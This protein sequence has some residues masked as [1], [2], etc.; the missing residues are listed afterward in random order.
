MFYICFPISYKLNLLPIEKTINQ[1][2]Q[3]LDEAH[4]I[5]TSNLKGSLALAKEAL[6]LSKK[7]NNLPYIAKCM[8]RLSL[9]NMI[10]GKTNT[11]TSY[12]NKAISYFEELN[13]ETGIADSKYSLAAVHYKTN[14]YHMGLVCL[15]DALKIYHKKNDYSNIS[16]TEKALGTVYEYIGDEKNA[17]IS[18]KNAIRAARIVNDLNL[19]S[20]VYNNL[21]G[22][23]VKKSKYKYSM[24][25]IERSIELK[26]QTKDIRGSGF[27]IYGRG[28]VFLRLNKL[29]EAE[30]DFKAAFDIHKKMGDI[31]GLS[32]S[33]TKLGELYFKDNKHDLAIQYALDG[34]KLT[35]KHNITM[36]NIKLFNLVYNIYKKIGKIELALEYLEYY[37]KEKESLIDIQTIKVIENYDFILKMKTLEKDNQIQKEKQEMLEIKRQDELRALKLKQEFLS[38]MSHEIRTPLNAITSIVALLNDEINEEGKDLLKSLKF[39]SSNLIKIVNDVLDFTKLDSNKSNLEVTTVNLFQLTENIKN[40]YIKQAEDKGLLLK[41]N[42]EIEDTC[43]YK[44]DETKITQILN[45]LIS[46][47]IKFTE[48]GFVELAIKR[49]KSAKR[50]DTILFEVKDTGEGV[51]SEN[52]NEI[53]ESFSQVKPVL[54]RKQGGTGLGLAIVKKIVALHG[55]EIKVK[56]IIGKGSTFYFTLKVARINNEENNFIEVHNK[57]LDVDLK[58]KRVLIVDDTLINAVLLKKLLSKW[59]IESEHVEK[60][61]LALEKTKN[62]KYDLILMDIHMPD[63][64]GLDVTRLIKTT[65]NLNT[66]TPVIA[67][68]AD[69][70]LTSQNYEINHFSGFLWKPFEIEKLKQELQKVFV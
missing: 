4:E 6:E 7:Q 23:L 46:N 10:L 56:S 44:F 55:G 36:I 31:M 64:N 11:A 20:N 16:R 63:M 48:T 67:L 29:V 30:K 2:V 45:N 65:I 50:F 9:Y 43:L 61:S 12:A 15:L 49:V 35:K 25:I 66:Q 38:V 37:I 26:N 1:V 3:L 28:K 5:R 59:E 19:E 60:G 17:I 8:S 54:T 18:Y 70:M 47:A 42:Y 22:L 40:V 58:G 34:I 68:T 13:D 62:T 33:Y 69:T 21:S 14:D 57:L 51:S 39:A 41:L 24:L 27:A 52:L 53:F 32:M